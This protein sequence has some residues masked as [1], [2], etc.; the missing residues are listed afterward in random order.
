M[1]FANLMS[2]SALSDISVAEH[3]EAARPHLR[4]ESP[5]LGKRFTVP[6]HTAQSIIDEAGNPQI[7]L[8][9]LDV[10]GAERSVLE[11]IDF[12]RARPRHM[13]IEARNPAETAAFLSKHGYGAAER[14]T[15]LDY[16]FAAD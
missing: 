6:A 8:F 10:E 14:L 4:S 9:V 16:L 2:L 5:I 3:L 13:L 12:A 1:A 7:D 15:A 11:G